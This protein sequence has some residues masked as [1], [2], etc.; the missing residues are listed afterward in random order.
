[1]PWTTH[2]FLSNLRTADCRLGVFHPRYHQ[3]HHSHNYYQEA[4]GYHP[5]ALLANSML[6]L[7]MWL[8]V[9]YQIK[10]ESQWTISSTCSLNDL[11][12]KFSLAKLCNLP[13]QG[14][15]Y[16][17]QVDKRSKLVKLSNIQQ[18]Y[19]SNKTFRILYMASKFKTK[20]LQFASMN[21][22]ILY[23]FLVSSSKEHVS[24]SAAIWL[25][26]LHK[27]IHP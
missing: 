12:M 2:W 3:H 14:I 22:Y 26:I 6:V 18:N 21:T 25:L 7:L 20:N 15:C 1:M 17:H 9:V 23:L 11:W 5:T 10:K 19:I 8:T 27:Q 13:V 24:F 16:I 4:A